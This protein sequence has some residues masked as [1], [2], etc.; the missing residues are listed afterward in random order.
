[1][2]VQT[3]T[4]MIDDVLSECLLHKQVQPGEIAFM[5]IS[6]RS[7]LPVC[8]GETAGSVSAWCSASAVFLGFTAFALQST[9]LL[10]T[11]CASMLARQDV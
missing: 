8:Q 4:H 10:S 2:S 6:R 7:G 9:L 1:M 11:S 3:I 5:E